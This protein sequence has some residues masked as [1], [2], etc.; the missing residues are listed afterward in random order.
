MIA[1]GQFCS[2][3][4]F[5]IGSI[6]I[7]NKIE[8]CQRHGYD[9]HVAC[10]EGEMGH[11]WARLEVLADLLRNHEWVFFIGCDTLIMNFNTELRYLIQEGKDLVITKD[12]LGLNSDVLFMRSCIWSQLFLARV[13]QCYETYHH[14]AWREQQAII[15]LAADPDNAEHIAVVPQRLMNSYL[16]SQYRGPGYDGRGYENHPDF[17]LGDFVLHLPGMSNEKRIPILK[18]Y[19]GK[20]VK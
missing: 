14:L 19:L 20:V 18:E 5:D 10:D 15:D 12:A 9:Y 17:E 2:N 3:S 16:Y 6:T 13:I 1:V 11:P 4:F 8:Y 7:P